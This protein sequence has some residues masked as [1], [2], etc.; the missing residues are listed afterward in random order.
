MESLPPIPTPPAQRW[1]EFRIQILPLV[2]FIITLVAIAWMWRNFV[3]PSGIVGQVEAIQ[4]NIISLNDGVITDLAVDRFQF[5]TNGQVLG[6]VQI[7]DPEM[8]KASL[9]AVES[10]LKVLQARIRLD[11]IRNAQSSQQWQLDLL[12]EQVA[13]ELAKVNLIVASNTLYQSEYLHKEGVESPYT[14]EINRSAKE[15]LEQEIHV[16]TVAVANWQ[17]AIKNAGGPSASANDPLIQEAIKAKEA[18][19][20]L[21]LQPTVLKAPMDGIVNV[22]YRRQREKVTRGEPIL[23]I[24]APK[25]ERV[26]GY[27]RQPVQSIPSVDDVVVIHTRTQKRQM[28]EG[29]IVKVGA[30][31]DVINPALLS[32]DSNRVEMGLPILVSIPPGMNVSPGEFVDLAIR[33]GKR[34]SKPF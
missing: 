28:G 7:T 26:V 34:D 3:Q 22:V 6:Q 31:F 25:S 16:R 2:V 13:L 18:E 21:T 1:R 24:S 30:Q 15:A 9:A 20:S 32:A 5:V 8:L 14:L 10:D 27:I 23:T 17:E 11:E 19:V 29:R 12:R 4:A 33:P